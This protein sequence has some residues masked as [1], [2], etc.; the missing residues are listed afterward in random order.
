MSLLVNSVLEDYQQSDNPCS[1]RAHKCRAKRS[2][3]ICNKRFSEVS[4]V[5]VLDD[6]EHSTK[7]KK[8]S[9]NRR[10]RKKIEVARG[11]NADA[12]ADSRGLEKKNSKCK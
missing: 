7:E 2:A 8:K 3:K 12:V 11:R 9:D 5:D 10:A 6:K 4:S 1:R